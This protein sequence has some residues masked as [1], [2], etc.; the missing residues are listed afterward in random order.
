MSFN[1]VAGK[2]ANPIGLV[3]ILSGNFVGDIDGDGADLTNVSH[4]KQSNAEENRIV[5]FNTSTT[6]LAGNERNIRGHSNFL[7]DPGSNVFTA[8]SG[9]VHARNSITSSHTISTGEYFIGCNHTA[10]ITITLPFSIQC[11]SGQTFIIKDESGNAS[12]LNIK[13]RVQGS[14]TIDGETNFTIDS[15]FGAVNLYSNGSNKFF[16]F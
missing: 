1:F 16:L 6:N 14:D 12:N 15:P 4:I 13:V 2:V 7:F 3:P 5:F 9:M 10:S 8:N 11:S